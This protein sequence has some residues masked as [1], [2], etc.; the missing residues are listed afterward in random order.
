LTIERYEFILL[1]MKIGQ[2]G[3]VTIPKKLRERFGLE[4]RIEVEF[5]DERGKLVLKK[6]ER[7]VD[8]VEAVEGSCKG[9]L[10]K[11]GF[12]T[13]GAYLEALRGR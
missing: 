8:P 1:D 4:P 11:L 9:S 13:P 12:A 3:Q 2:R 7:G 10:K 5:V 6:V